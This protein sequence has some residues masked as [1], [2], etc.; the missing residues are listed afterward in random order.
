MITIS[1]LTKEYKDGNVKGI[2]DITYTFPDTGLVLIRGKSGSGKSTL[3]HILSCLLPPSSGECQIEGQSII[4]AKPAK[5]TAIR[6]K[7]I[8]FCGQNND[9]LHFLT[10]QENVLLYAKETNDA[11]LNDLLSALGILELKDRRCD[12]ISGGQAR[13]VALARTIYLD[14]PILVFDEPLSGLDHDTAEQVMGFLKMLSQNH[15]IVLA[16]HDEVSPNYASSILTLS[17]GNLISAEESIT[18]TKTE[19]PGLGIKRRGH[20]SIEAKIVS[21]CLKSTPLR[22]LLSVLFLSLCLGFLMPLLGSF[23]QSQESMLMEAIGNSGE[24]SSLTKRQNHFAVK[25]T[26]EESNQIA[27][28]LKG[29][30]IPVYGNGV[31]R[32]N[33]GNFSANPARY[34]VEQPEK[35]SK[36]RLIATL[37]PCGYAPLEPSFF[38]SSDYKLYGRSVENDGECVLPYLYFELY[39]AF[40]FQGADGIVHEPNSFDSPDAFFKINPSIYAP[41]GT[42]NLTLSVV[43][44]IDTK[45]PLE[46]YPDFLSFVDPKT[47]CLSQQLQSSFLDG[48]HGLT[49]VHPHFIQTHFALQ[50]DVSCTSLG[51]SCQSQIRGIT[52]NFTSISKYRG[53]TKNL[54]ASLAGQGSSSG[55]YLGK[56]AFGRLCSTLP[57]PEEAQYDYATCLNSLTRFSLLEADTR[58][59]RFD[60]LLDQPSSYAYQPD[61]LLLASCGAYVRT[62]GLPKDDGLATLIEYANQEYQA[63]KDRGAT[64]ETI[65]F[66]QQ[67]EKTLDYLK[68]FYVRMLFS[69]KMKMEETAEIAPNVAFLRQILSQNT[70]NSIPTIPLSISDPAHGTKR[71]DVK[72][73]GVYLP[74]D[75]TYGK[76]LCASEELYP[77]LRD[78]LDETAGICRILFKT[79]G[80]QAIATAALQ[81]RNDATGVSLRHPI[82]SSYQ[83]AQTYYLPNVSSLT[84]ALTIGLGATALLFQFINSATWAKDRLSEMRLRR[85][86]GMNGGAVF[87]HLGASVIVTSLL[88]YLLSVP[89][90]YI[91]SSIFNGILRSSYGLGLPY[92]AFHILDASLALAFTLLLAMLSILPS[93]LSSLKKP[94]VQPFNS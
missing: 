90:A 74:V 78:T 3:L 50:D 28:G 20:L 58:L 5:L 61:R 57:V 36:Q 44:L 68:S 24:F 81:K 64:Q 43:G 55:I 66:H 38:E 30:V 80:N 69:G 18:P 93:S 19:S 91:A 11:K 75:D 4:K 12:H 9:L 49:F 92:F 41:T 77:S 21:H 1:R 31:L 59:S 37:N 53:A 22:S 7:Y 6:K 2:A 46:S 79:Q 39:Q 76:A 10:V 71:I 86:L 94:L 54:V 14:A 23:T 26:K 67:D 35:E 8:G 88:S 16:S 48:I 56:T 33:N 25:F 70:P 15:L 73:L 63:Q 85:A 27:S 32:E 13:R 40:G 60:Y 89:L 47:A 72:V 34:I 52:Y 82:V 84:L 45:L 51:Q 65:D 29:T 87:L 83:Y 17:Q 62:H 42:G